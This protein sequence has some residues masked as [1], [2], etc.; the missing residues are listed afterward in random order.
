[1][2]IVSEKALWMRFVALMAVLAV[3]LAACGNTTSS[4]GESEDDGG[5]EAPGASEPAASGGG[6]GGDLGTYTAGIFQDMTS[7]NLWHALDTAGN[8]VWNSYILTPNTCGLYTVSYPGIEF[9]P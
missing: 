8:T 6:A 9:V 7:D 1:M 2:A 4:P 3:V 5:S